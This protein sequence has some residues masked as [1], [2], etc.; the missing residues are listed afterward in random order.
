MFCKWL[1]DK[2]KCRL[3][4]QFPDEEKFLFKEELGFADA[5]HWLHE[6]MLDVIAC[7]FVR[8]LIARSDEPKWGNLEG[9]L[10]QFNRWE[11]AIWNGAKNEC[12]EAKGKALRHDVQATRR[13]HGTSPPIKTLE[14]RAPVP[15]RTAFLCGPSVRHSGRSGRMISH[16]KSA[17][18][19]EY[20]CIAVLVLCLAW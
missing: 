10:D 9:S 13:M 14:T 18:L 7:G 20:S 2:F 3:L 11:P 16:S 4:F 19:L 5:Q 8:A 12:H 6:N 17:R 15:F 1:Q